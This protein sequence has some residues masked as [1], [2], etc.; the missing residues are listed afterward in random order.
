MLMGFSQISVQLGNMSQNSS[1][2]NSRTGSPQATSSPRTEPAPPGFTDSNTFWSFQPPGHT[3]NITNAQGGAAVPVFGN[4]DH[5]IY[6]NVAADLFPAGSGAIMTIPELKD[7]AIWNAFFYKYTAYLQQQGIFQV[8]TQTKPAASASG[9]AEWYTRNNKALGVFKS[10]VNQAFESLMTDDIKETIEN[11]Q[12]AFGQEDTARLLN[13]YEEFHHATF[14]SNQNPLPVITKMDQKRKELKVLGVDIPES[15]FVLIVI[16]KL[17]TGP[18][19]MLKQ[20]IIQEK[21]EDLKVVK[22][23][24]LITNEW[25]RRRGAHESALAARISGI[26]CFIPSTAPPWSRQNRQPGGNSSRSNNRKNNNRSGNGNNNQKQNNNNQGNHNQQSQKGKGKGKGKAGKKKQNNQ[27]KQNGR[28]LSANLACATFD[29]ELMAPL[30]VYMANISTNPLDA[31]DTDTDSEH[32]SMP[33]LV[34]LSETDEID[35]E[36][37]SDS[38]SEFEEGEVVEQPPIPTTSQWPPHDVNDPYAPWAPPL[39]ESV[40]D[41]Y[42]PT[43]APSNF[44]YTPANQQSISQFLILYTQEN[45]RNMGRSKLRRSQYPTTICDIRLP[46]PID[47][48][49]RGATSNW[50]D[51]TRYREIMDIVKRRNISPEFIFIMIWTTTRVVVYPILHRACHNLTPR[52]ALYLQN[53]C[54]PILTVRAFSQTRFWTWDVQHLSEA[55]LEINTTNWVKIVEAHP[56]CVSV[57]EVFRIRNTRT[58]IPVQVYNP[59]FWG[60]HIKLGTEGDWLFGT[61]SN[62]SVRGQRGGYKQNNK[63]NVRFVPRLNLC[64]QFDRRTTVADFSPPGT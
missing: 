38:S 7:S 33:S 59:V 42:F 62:Q 27:G 52:H 6:A 53:I 25:N 23:I 11:F 49:F 44:P 4:L 58:P 29:Q 9:Y 43:F 26:H 39:P 63:R 30:R 5:P 50:E 21:K 17:P 47:V 41:I 40:P 55:I 15:L 60:A 24:A 1:Q 56:E 61:A 45:V 10:R 18:W 54:E 48:P 8:L 2:H 32:S 13:I 35:M 34:T 14:F 16:A 12:K 36:I 37:S 31:I 57:L 51:E 19:E 64:D 22:L 28:H 3:Y 20:K 46:L